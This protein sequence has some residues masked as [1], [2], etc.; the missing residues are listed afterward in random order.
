MTRRPGES[1]LLSGENEVLQK[2]AGIAPASKIFHGNSVPSARHSSE[3]WN[4]VPLQIFKSLDS[5]FRSLLSGMR[6]AN[7]WRRDGSQALSVVCRCRNPK[8]AR[9][10]MAVIPAKAGIHFKDASE[11]NGFPLSRE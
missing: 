4:P 9:S 6:F 3:S 1:P 2:C 11:Q 10:S 8:S 5:S 7:P